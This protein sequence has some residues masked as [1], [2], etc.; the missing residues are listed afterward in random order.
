MRVNMKMNIICII[1][2]ELYINNNRLSDYFF[3]QQENVLST[4]KDIN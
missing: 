2:L 4:I 3:K 1:L